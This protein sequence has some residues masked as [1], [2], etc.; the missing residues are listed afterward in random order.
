M[1]NQS[2]F[3]K[4]F[5]IPGVMFFG[6]TSL[7]WAI[8]AYIPIYFTDLGF[9]HFEISILLSI[10]PLVSLVLML[11]FGIF[12]DKLSPKKLV[13]ISLVLFAAFLLG[14]RQTEGFWSLLFLFIIGGIGDSLFRISNMSLYYKTLGDTNKGKKLGFF[15]GFGLLGY[16][17]GPLLGGYL[18]TGFDMNF[19]LWVILLILAPFFI[20]SFFLQDVEPIPFSD[21]EISRLIRPDSIANPILAN[22][23]RDEVNDEFIGS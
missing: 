19:L 18:L 5:V 14:L 15:M 13:I 17:I 3:V 7:L 10:F 20:L 2:G 12:S 21:S 6:Y 4:R 9:S 22:I 1:I 11:P 23:W 16:G 8:L